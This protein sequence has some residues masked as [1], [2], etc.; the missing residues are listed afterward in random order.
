[1]ARDRHTK[2]NATPRCARRACQRAGSARSPG[3]RPRSP[4]GTPAPDKGT[5]LPEA[6]GMPATTSSAQPNARQRW[7]APPEETR[8]GD[9]EQ[10]AGS[11]RRDQVA[12]NASSVMAVADFSRAACGGTRERQP[13]A[14]FQR[15]RIT[16]RRRRSPPP[17]PAACAARRARACQRTPTAAGQQPRRAHLV[18][19]RQPEHDAE[20]DPQ[21]RRAAVGQ[22]RQ[23]HRS[24][25][26]ALLSL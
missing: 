23:Q 26:G 6:A 10:P 3:C 12:T 2:L 16:P 25:L 4:P 17:T 8:A 7:R 9:P 19:H 11:H 14:A 1:M 18:Q 13:L 15:I 21:S 24:D 5:R 22:S 20:P